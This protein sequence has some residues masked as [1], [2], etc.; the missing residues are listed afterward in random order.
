M[1]FIEGKVTEKIVD[2][3]FYQSLDKVKRMYELAEEIHKY[4]AI[5]FGYEDTLKFE[6]ELAFE[7]GASFFIPPYDLVEE[8]RDAVPK[9]SILEKEY[10]K[11]VEKLH[12][13][14]EY[15]LFADDK[16]H[17]CKQFERCEKCFFGGKEGCTYGGRR[18]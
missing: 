9:L 10:F 5:V 1:C 6:R 4:K 3:I 2:H 11:V 13:A 7:R 15:W 14:R 8:Y 17:I 16:L 12:K 18:R